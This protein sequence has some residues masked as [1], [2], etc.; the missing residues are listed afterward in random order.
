MNA[1][2]SGEGFRGGM[3]FEGQVPRES[4]AGM[5]ELLHELLLAPRFEQDEFNVLR[6]SALSNLDQMRT[7][8]PAVAQNSLRRYLADHP[9]DSVLHVP[10][11]DDRRLQLSE[12]KAE[13]CRDLYQQV[14][15][16]EFG[17]WC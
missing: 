16:G 4:L 11:M 7:Q 8:P 12:L 6:A 2:L 17:E 9:S 13:N 15:G 3:T 14:M 5:F 10:T 1:W